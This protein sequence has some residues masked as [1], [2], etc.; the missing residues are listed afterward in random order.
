M[1]APDEKPWYEKEITTSVYTVNAGWYVEIVIAHPDNPEMP[2]QLMTVKCDNEWW[3]KFLEY[4]IKS[5][6]MEPAQDREG[7]RYSNGSREEFDKTAPEFRY[8][9]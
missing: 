4:A 1:P 9:G 7:L 5:L 2:P 8:E 6:L 3:A